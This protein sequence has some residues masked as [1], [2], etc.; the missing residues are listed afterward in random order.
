MRNRLY[1]RAVASP[2]GHITLGG[3]PTTRRL[4]KKTVQWRRTYHRRV[5]GWRHWP[6]RRW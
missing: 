3:P 1:R 4:G 5:T 6:H 2:L